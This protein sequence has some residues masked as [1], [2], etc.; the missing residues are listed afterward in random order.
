VCIVR[1]EGGG[2][3]SGFEPAGRI[4][5]DSQNLERGVSNDFSFWVGD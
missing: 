1:V 2:G 5:L 4:P 3:R